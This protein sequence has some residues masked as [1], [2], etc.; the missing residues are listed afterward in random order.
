MS[1]VP[2]FIPQ[3]NLRGDPRLREGKYRA[4]LHSKEV[5]GLTFELRQLDSKAGCSRYGRPW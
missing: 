3:E 5:V 1:F 4:Q 2:S